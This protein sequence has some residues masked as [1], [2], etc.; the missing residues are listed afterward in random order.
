MAS[1]L[2]K[3]PT[4]SV[5]RWISF[6]RVLDTLADKLPKVAAHL[7]AARADVLAFTAF[8][9][10]LSRQI[11]SNNPSER[12]RGRGSGRCCTRSTTSPTRG[13]GVAEHSLHA[14]HTRARG[15]RQ[16][17][18]GVAELIGCPAWTHPAGPGATPRHFDVRA[19]AALDRGPPRRRHAPAELSS[20]TQGVLLGVD[21]WSSVTEPATVAD[22]GGHRRRA[23]KFASVC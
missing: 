9:K 21:G 1:R 18:C 3:M 13:G 19:S 15:D 12:V 14:L 16:G 8:P 20:P 11:W 2:G 6:D 17:R 22:R 10:E 23:A 4:T 7:D 5:R